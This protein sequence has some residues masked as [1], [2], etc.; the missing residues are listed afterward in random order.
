MM[1]RIHDYAKVVGKCE[2]AVRHA[3]IDGKIKYKVIDGKKYIDENTPW[4]HSE[5]DKPNTWK[6]GLSDHPLRNTWSCMKQR[7]Y[8]PKNRS[9]KTYG[10]RGITVCDEWRDS[11]PAFLQW[12]NTHGY[13]KGLTIDRIDNNKGYCPNN[14]RFIERS[15]NS[16]KR[17]EEMRV[18]NEKREVDELA[19]K[20]AE[21]QNEQWYVIKSIKLDPKKI[22]RSSKRTNEK[23]SELL[24]ILRSGFTMGFYNGITLRYSLKKS[25]YTISGTLYKIPTPSMEYMKYYLDICKIDY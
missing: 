9:F 4:F 7:C 5:N 24:D 1:L 16:R 21:I 8:N 3:I 11:F 12:A 10:A 14:C 17:R 19:E 18:E 13:V 6:H 2:A 22:K 15:E 20:I 23:M 25:K